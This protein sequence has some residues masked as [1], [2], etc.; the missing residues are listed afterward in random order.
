ME[1]V[2]SATEARTHFGEMMRR[3]AEEEEAIVVEKGGTPQL[4]MLSVQRYQHLKQMQALQRQTAWEQ[5][6]AVHAMIRARRGDD[7]LVPSPAEI[8]R[9]LREERDEQLLTH[10]R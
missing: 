8:I 4:V 7:P 1:T 3:V 5:I 2:V 6:T 10:L 9:R